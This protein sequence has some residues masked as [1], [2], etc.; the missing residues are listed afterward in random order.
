MPAR[1]PR[2]RLSHS[3][4]AMS[5]H[6]TPVRAAAA[7]ASALCL[8]VG[9]S[10]PPSSPVA[11]ETPRY[12]GP[13]ITL[14]LGTDDSPGVPSADQISH[15]A[16]EVATL[17]GGK[18]TIEPIWHAEGDDHPTDW[19]QAVAAMV[20]AGKL[21]LALGPTWAWDVLGVTSFR[22]LQAPFLVDSDALVAKVVTDPDLP[23]RLMSGLTAA[24]VAGISL[25]PEGLRHP[26]GFAKPLVKPTDYAGTTIR[27]ARSKA[28]T[29]LFQA[30]GAATSAK[31]PNAKTMAG[32]QGEFAL[33]PNGIGV[34]NVTFF[35]KVNV[36]YANANSYAGLDDSARR[37]LGLAAETTQRWAIEQASDV[38]SGSDFC[39]D[40]GTI[41]HANDRDVAALRAATAKVAEAIAVESGNGEVVRA[42]GQLKSAVAAV[43]PAEACAGQEELADHEPGPAEA[44][45]NGTY[46]FT[47]SR[48]DFSAADKSAS[49][50]HNNAGVQ[51]FTLADGKAQFRLDPSEHAYDDREGEDRAE[52][53]YRVNGSAITFRFPS[54]DN[55]VDRLLF[56]VQ[57]NGDLKMTMVKTTDPL[58]E[59]LMTAKPWKKIR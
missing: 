14:T 20:R 51:T 42:I 24:D 41:I 57:D 17:S 34:A 8:A 16:A 43:Q 7:A 21:D 48:T 47:L 28:I 3:V 36:L 45:L 52:G 53:T 6:R 50:A 35:P 54:F 27:S 56:E 4:R 46:R 26:F 49:Q 13:A 40:G 33:S 37:V 30:L 5:T 38:R 2:R 9:C 10:G 44:A 59:F 12:A 11:S 55:E 31:E 58:V 15:F 22:P 39:A 23:A 25:W 29:E 1:K 32:V 18:V 19:D